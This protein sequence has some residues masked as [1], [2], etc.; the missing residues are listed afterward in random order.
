MPEMDGLEATKII[1]DLDKGKDI[2]IIALTAHALKDYE[3]KSFDAG[4]NGYLTK[5]VD[6]NLLTDELNKVMINGLS[7]HSESA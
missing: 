3:D 7:T 4:M 5:P 2:P 1:R 6:I